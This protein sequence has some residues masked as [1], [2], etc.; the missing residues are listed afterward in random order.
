[1]SYPLFQLVTDNGYV[2]PKVATVLQIRNVDDWL[3]YDAMDKDLPI[4]VVSNN[5]SDEEQLF[6][7]PYEIGTVVKFVDIKFEKGEYKLYVIGLYRA[8][9]T[10]YWNDE[11]SNYVTVERLNEKRLDFFNMEIAYS[12]LLD[13]F[14]KYAS[15]EDSLTAYQIYHKFEPHS[16]E[17]KEDYETMEFLMNKLT[18]L[19]IDNFPF[20]PT[21]NQEIIE[22]DNIVARVDKV[23]ELIQEML[24]ENYNRTYHFPDYEDEL[25][26]LSVLDQAKEKAKEDNELIESIE[27]FSI[28]K[29]EQEKNEQKKPRKK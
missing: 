21:F 15:L 14:Y 29:L 18:Q 16:F 4:F 12:S 24:L 2:L 27:K 22:E 25:P 19:A 17:L 3:L 9:R 26:T 6:D 20:H 10:A 28:P 5:L 1:M 13:T 11:H 23:I 7:C 8:K